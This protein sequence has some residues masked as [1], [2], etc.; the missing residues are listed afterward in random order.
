MMVRNLSFQAL[1][2]APSLES[3]LSPI[4]RYKLEEVRIAASMVFL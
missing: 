1:R 4:L 2:Q 3:D